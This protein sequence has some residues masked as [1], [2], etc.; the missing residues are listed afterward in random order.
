MEKAV[1]QGERLYLQ[2]VQL[3]QAKFLERIELINNLMQNS[4]II[5]YLFNKFYGLKIHQNE[6]LDHSSLMSGVNDEIHS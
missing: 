1:T 4:T 5:P 3:V 2:I 6:I